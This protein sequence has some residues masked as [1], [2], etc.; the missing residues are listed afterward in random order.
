MNRPIAISV[1]KWTGLILLVLI[2][3]FAVFVAVFDWNWLRGPI[4]RQATKQTGRELVIAG[5]LSAQLAW[6]LPRLR[7][8]GV[9]F[10]NP[11]WAK[12]KQMLA[13]DVVEITLSLPLLFQR[14]IVLPEVRLEQP[15]VFL[16]QHA[17]GRRNWLLDQEQ[18]DEES[19]VVIGRL[20][21][22]HGRISFDDSAHKTHIESEVSS[23]GLQGEPTGT[24]IEFSAHGEYKG[25]ALNA[26]GSGGPVL[27][28]RDE[29]KP[30]PIKIDAKVGRTKVK[31]DGE[32]TS[33]T[34]LSALDMQLKLSGD[35]LASLYQLLGILLPNTHAYSTS[36]R[37]T[38]S[39]KIW[40]Y[41]KFT[42]L[43]GNSD[44]AGTIHVDT[45]GE[46]P[47]LRGDLVS[48]VLDFDDLGPVIG[49]A[50]QPTPES[51]MAAPVAE[52]GRVL[53]DERFRTERWHST[54]AD[55]TFKATTFRRAKA[56]PITD[57]ETHL[58]L[59]DALLTLDPLTFGVA[60]GNI[61]STVTLDGRH[62]PIDA[63]AKL[64]VKKLQLAKLFPTTDLNKAS[65]GEVD[66]EFDL[67][68]RG[69]S[70]ASMLAT[71]NGKLGLVA[72]GGEISK[73]AM[74]MAG[75]H[76]LEILQLKFSGDH[77][78]KLRCAIADFDV[79]NGVMQTNALV[80]DTDVT[81]VTGSGNVDLGQERLD[82]TL[83]TH[84][85]ETSILSLHAPIHVRGTFAHPSATPDKKSMV[86]RGLGAA[87]LAVVNPFLIV[88]P[89]IDKGPGKDSDC[90]QLVHAEQQ[91][92]GIKDV[93][94]VKR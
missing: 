60:G 85:K 15:V 61:V 57:L 4:E 45:S 9:T 28:L 33:L 79:K 91:A 32:I 34:R 47:F 35:S 54:D 67:A 68:G 82:L 52:R 49:A 73:M 21:L 64:H 87:A 46:R 53:P 8:E 40:H 81:T 66:G 51:P 94:A 74:E 25:E 63:H 86:M 50:K 43:V 42:G 80:L 65:I 17:D 1:L 55:V 92:A 69:N 11:P 24:G 3:L 44:I 39:G 14:H 90:G 71:A 93:Q 78:I 89:L 48:K 12:E 70:I 18:R 62:D 30:Y 16:E 83:N 76:V 59:N 10:A 27:A 20:T 58:K 2:A 41:E 75:L 26:K 56:L 6:P 31:A 77:P 88:L 38:H 37:I 23:Q 84:T 22:D 36:G 5:N 19:G 7:A 13:A 29:S 72:P